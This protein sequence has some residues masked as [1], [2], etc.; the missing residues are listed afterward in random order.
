MLTRKQ[1][2]YTHELIKRRLESHSYESGISGTFLDSADAMIEYVP[3]DDDEEQVPDPNELF[4]FQQEQNMPMKLLLVPSILE[5][6]L[7]QIIKLRMV[8]KVFGFGD[9]DEQWLNAVTL[10]AAKR[11]S[12]KLMPIVRIC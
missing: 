11:Q 6:P 8:E 5:Q 7:L 2:V 9:A 1:L 12:P 4:L 3:I 10:D